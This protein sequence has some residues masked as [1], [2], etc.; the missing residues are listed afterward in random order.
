MVGRPGSFLQFPQGTEGF[1]LEEAYTHKR[2]VNRIEQTFS[3]WGYL[4]VQTPVFDFYDV[5]KPLLRRED[6]KSAYRLIDRD[7]ELLMLRSDITLFLAKQMGMV[8]TDEDLPVRVY[9]ADTIL[10]HQDPEDISRNEFFQVGIELIGAPG[11]EAD[12]EVLLLLKELL[13]VIHAPPYFIHI[14][15]RKFID[16]CTPDADDTLRT[17]IR[18]A[19]GAR[20]ISAVRSLFARAGVPETRIPALVQLLFFIGSK[21]EL[22]G[23]LESARS[24]LTPAQTAAVTSLLDLSSTLDQLGATPAFRIDLSEVGSQAYHSGIVFQAYMDG[25]DSAT[26]SGG[27]YDGLLGSFGFDAPSVGFSLMLRKLQNSLGHDPKAYEPDPL[28]AAEGNTFVERVR[29]AQNL[30]KSG[31]RVIL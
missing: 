5:Y 3:S 13:D 1:Y 27:R 7:G 30:R 19:V 9:Y 24:L 25:F 22:H 29:N 18:Q 16:A 4:P 2:L 15:T 10:R 8:L 21:D 26:A 31:K 28:T 17:H 20:D 6:K 14:G 11:P 12:L 23:E